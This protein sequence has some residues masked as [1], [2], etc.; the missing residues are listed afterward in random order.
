MANVMQ[1]QAV[2]SEQEWVA[3]RQEL[4]KKEKELTRHIDEVSRLRQALP[5]VKVE[6]KYTFEGPE[7]PVSLSELFDGRSQ[8]IV[9]HFMYAPEWDEGCSG[10]SFLADHFD[11][12]RQHFEHHDVTLVAVSRAPLAKLEAFKKRMGW[13][14][15]WV[16]SDDGD[17]NYDYHASYRRK[18]LDAGPVFHNFTTQKLTGED[19]PG[20]SV[21]I[22]DQNGEIFHTYSSYERGLDILVGVHNF[23]DL[24]PK[25]R[26]E[27]SAMNWVRLHD[28][29]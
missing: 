16:S 5:W 3:A 11:G 15:R 29:Y 12:P 23:L 10:C 6:K 1:E 20:L 7:G 27:D 2:V 21:F 14:F 24:T 19:Q 18:D 13:T 25:G 26:N 4:L 22:K 8:L 28:E 17:F 9:Y